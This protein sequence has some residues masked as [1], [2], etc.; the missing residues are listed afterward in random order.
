MLDSF[1]LVSLVPKE[2]VLGG[3]FVLNWSC[4]KPVGDGLDVGHLHNPEDVSVSL[5]VIQCVQVGSVS[6]SEDACI[7][8]NAVFTAVF[9]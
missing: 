4:F 8:L 6:M 7:L 9:N 1:I 2:L 5:C 3:S